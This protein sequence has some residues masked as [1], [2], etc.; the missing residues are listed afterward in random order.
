MEHI[1]DA[2]PLASFTTSYQSEKKPNHPLVN[3][4]RCKQRVSRILSRINNL[5]VA[6]HYEG[7][8][9]ICD[10]AIAAALAQGADVPE[11]LLQAS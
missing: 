1:R 10:L 2:N 11:N 9:E 5:N 4:N 6:R 7:L 3:A 8:L